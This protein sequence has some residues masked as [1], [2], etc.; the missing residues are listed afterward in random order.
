MYTHTHNQHEKSSI[1]TDYLYGIEL[2]VIF[3]SYYKHLEF[4]QYIYNRHILA[5]Y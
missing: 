1:N 4:F 5:L 2:L 3:I